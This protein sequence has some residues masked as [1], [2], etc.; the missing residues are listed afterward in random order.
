M[1]GETSLYGLTHLYDPET[2]TTAVSWAYR[3]SPE[4][5]YFILETYDEVAKKWV[6]YDNLMGIIPKDS[7]Y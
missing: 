3:D 6:P 1:N 2:D 4:L 7:P 5:E